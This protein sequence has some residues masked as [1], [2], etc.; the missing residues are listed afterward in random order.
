MNKALNIVVVDDEP[1]AIERLCELLLEIPNCQVIGKAVNSEIAWQVINSAKPDLILLDIAMPGESGLQLA[2]RIQSLDKPPMVVFCTAYDEHA[3]KAFEAHAID[4]L[5]KPIR[6][7]RLLESVE[8]A[9]R[10]K[11]IVQTGALKQFVTTSVGG[12]LRRIALV[13]IYY[14]HAEE[15]YTVVHHRGGEHILDQSLKD[16]EQ[17][18]P[19]EFMRIHRN[20]LV[21]KEQLNIVRRD[22]EGHV[23]AQL[24]DVSTPLEVSR[25]CS[26]DLKEWFKNS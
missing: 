9:M 16:L 4:Y 20:C 10:M 14:I 7:E 3:L 6:R 19:E 17:G 11:Q 24:R 15:K 23:W 26:S 18:F 25:R 1:L 12:I 8:R 21:K 22:T 5:L 13:E 2:T